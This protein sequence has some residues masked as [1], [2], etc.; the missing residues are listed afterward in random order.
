MI[1]SELA[2]RIRLVAL[3]VDGVL[4]EGGIYL[5]SVGGEQLE[6]KR[7]DIQDGMGLHLLGMAGIRLAILTGRESESVRLRARELGIDDCVQDRHARKLPAFEQLCERRGIGPEE[8]AFIGDDFPDVGILRVVG[9]PVSVANAVPEVKAICS[10]QLSRSGGRG[11]V[12]EFAEL[13]LKAR[14]E[15]EELIER[16]VLE[17][18]GTGERTGAPTG[19]ALP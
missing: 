4:T 10:V 9:L 5:G 8:A 16:Y 15:W 13:L 7:Y 1:D 17:R 11:A 3:D 14:G 2:R 6:F 18:S 19:A 12:R